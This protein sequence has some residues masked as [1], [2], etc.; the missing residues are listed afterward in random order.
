MFVLQFWIWMFH[1]SVRGILFLQP[2]LKPADVCPCTFPCNWYQWLYAE[3]LVIVSDHCSP[4]IEC[5]SGKK[6]LYDLSKFIVLSEDENTVIFAFFKKFRCTWQIFSWMITNMLQKTLTPSVPPNQ[7][8]VWIIQVIKLFDLQMEGEAGLRD[9]T[10]S[11]ISS[12]TITGLNFNKF[13]FAER[14]CSTSFSN[15]L[16][17][18][19]KSLDS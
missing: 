5:Y 10:Y 16:T 9:S 18:Y 2:G 11:G 15:E 4:Y 1:L 19:P 14:Y 8:W 7:E 17:F 6:L 12:V 13:L 3:I